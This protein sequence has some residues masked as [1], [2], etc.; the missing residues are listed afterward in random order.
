MKKRGRHGHNSLLLRDLLVCIS[1]L[2]Y[3][4]SQLRIVR[5]GLHLVTY[6]DVGNFCDNS[7]D[8][9]LN[10]ICVQVFFR[11]SDS[12]KSTQ[13]ISLIYEFAW[14][15]GFHKSEENLLKTSCKAV[16]V[17]KVAHIFWWL[18]GHRKQVRQGHVNIDATLVE[19]F[20]I[21]HDGLLWWCSVA[22]TLLGWRCKKLLFFGHRFEFH[23]VRSLMSH[24][25]KVSEISC[26]T[27]H[28]WYLSYICDIT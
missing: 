20:C 15:A 22:C 19:I 27:S 6:L 4:V 11:F 5:S 8:S 7:T 16:S 21:T 12:T 25:N 18:H 23:C 9:T 14:L 26:L 28:Q 2:Q 17:T 13:S 1:H 3:A 10:G 24:H